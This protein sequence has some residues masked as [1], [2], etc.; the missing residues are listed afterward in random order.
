M[1]HL[2]PKGSLSFSFDKF[3]L[4]SFSLALFNSNNN[5]S[6]SNIEFFF[7]CVEYW[8]KFVKHVVFFPSLHNI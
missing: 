2:A 4:L 3:C 1:I 7:F 5:Y 8:T 6:K